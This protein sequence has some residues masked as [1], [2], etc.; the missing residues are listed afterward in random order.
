MEEASIFDT[1][2]TMGLTSASHICQRV[3]NAVAF[4]MFKIGILMLNYLDDFA[5]AKTQNKAEFAYQTFG[6]IQENVE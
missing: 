4:I 1:F 6:A 3:T 2:L 5:S